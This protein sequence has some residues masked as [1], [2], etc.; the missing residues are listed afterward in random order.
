MTLCTN[1]GA[2]STNKQEEFVCVALC[3]NYGAKSKNK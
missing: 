2:K 1:Y 3:T